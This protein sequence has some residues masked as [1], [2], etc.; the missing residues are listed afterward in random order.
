MTRNPA[1]VDGNY[2]FYIGYAPRL[3]RRIARTV[4]RTVIG[5]SALMIA[6]ALVLVFAQQPFARSTFEFQQ[7]RDFTGVV[8]LKPYPTL[9]VEH[10][11]AQDYSRYLLVAPGKHGADAEVRAFTGKQVA[12]RGS[13]IYRDGHTMIELVPGSLKE[14]HP[15]AGQASVTNLG[16]VTLTGEIV[17]SK[18]YLGVMNPGR[19]KVHRDCAARC[20][21]GGIPP[22]L[23]TT[24]GF[25]LLVGGDGR[26]L[27]EELIPWVAETIEVHGELESSGETLIL[28]M[29]PASFRRL[30]N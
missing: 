25:Y 22:A 19:T 9:V 29:E 12:L 3:P 20:I 8:E 28:R 1:S 6:A 17:D 7:Y 21:S 23:V 11:G 13:L 4:F 14:Q 15:A 5:L 26:P 10:P 18:C 16:A 24:D 30:R 2:E 27:N